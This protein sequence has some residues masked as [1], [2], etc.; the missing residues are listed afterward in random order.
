MGVLLRLKVNL[1]VIVA[2]YLAL[3]VMY[4]VASPIFEAPDESNHF[5]VI[6][7]IRETG[8]LPVLEA[9]AE[10]LHVQEGGQPPL[11]YLSAALLTAWIDTSAARDSLRPNPFVNIGNPGRPNNKNH[12]IHTAAE[13]FP[14]QGTALAVHVVRWLSIGLGLI[15]VVAT[16]A[17]A[18]RLF[19]D[20]RSVALL[21]AALVAFNPQFIYLSA[22]VNNDNALIALAACSL[23]LLARL[24][25]GDRSRR[26]VLTLGAVIGLAVL[27]KLG[28]LILLAFA[29]AVI[30][31]LAVTRRAWR[32]SWQAVVTLMIPVVIVAGWWFA[33]NIQLY[34][35][36]TG[37]RLMVN[38]LG[39]ERTNITVAE[40]ISEL[41]SLW[42][43]AWGVFGWFNF[44][45]PDWA[46]AIYTALV[47]G[48]LVGGGL[49]LRQQRRY[50]RRQIEPIAALAIW[51]SLAFAG[52]LYW[53]TFVPAFQ[54]RLVFSALPAMAI[55]LALGLIRLLDRVKIWGPAG[56]GVVLFATAA[57]TPFGVIAPAYAIP[58]TITLA[59]IPVGVKRVNVD[60]N[61]TV[62]LIGGYAEP[63]TLQANDFVTIRLYWQALR[64]SDRDYVAVV[65]L[66]GRDLERIGGDDLYPGAGNYPTD[67]WQAGEI[68]ADT[69]VLRVKAAARVPTRV[70]VAISLRDRQMRQRITV[71]ASDGTALPALVVV[72]EL[73]L[74]PGEPP[75]APE[76]P[77]QYRFS[78]VIDLIGYD[79]PRIDA[80]RQTV[81]YRLYWRAVSQ[82]VADYTVFDHILDGNGGLIGQGDSEPFDG[83]YPTSIW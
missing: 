10:T 76:Q 50:A 20:R 41:P 58:R 22:S 4:S 51:T 9:G 61:Q 28:G 23:Y 80:D 57:W 11:Y 43:S 42:F 24:W 77:T 78:E 63:R 59:D 73:R 35:D 14:Y 71:T 67:L 7:Y 68:L 65:R 29:I 44:Q 12:Y 74:A 49:A 31:Y 25:R 53:E 15:T 75:A 40:I 1:R 56:L 18:R 36:L 69:V 19:P 62:R 39:G 13:D 3:G 47:A 52:V 55:L 37:T 30:G 83:D 45:L 33:R 16:A 32:W 70:R 82:P 2:A 17:T 34:G 48:A 81:V 54:A 46:F 72:D 60:F 6:Q 66:L 79:A 21:A 5:F 27:A 64:Q 38:L 8:R 26:I